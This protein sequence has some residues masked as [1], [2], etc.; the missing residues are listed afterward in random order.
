MLLTNNKGVSLILSFCL[1]ISFIALIAISTFSSVNAYNKASHYQNSTKAFWIA[2]AGVNEYLNNP[3]ILNKGAISID[4]D[5]NIVNVSKDDVSTDNR[6]LKAEGIVNGV[7]K[8]IELIFPRKTPEIF[9][10][11]VSSGGNFKI[12]GSP[13]VIEVMDTA[14][15]T[16]T[17]Q[18]LD[19]LSTARFQNLLEKSDSSLTTLKYPDL[20][21]NGKVNEFNDFII[22]NRELLASFPKKETI[23]IK[24]NSTQII[25]PNN[26]LKDKK[27]IY[28]EGEAPGA[29][30]VIIL[31]NASSA[32]NQDI[33]IISTGSIY[34]LQP[35]QLSEKSQINLIAWNNY[36]E[37]SIFQSK[38][39]GITFAHNK[40]NFSC[41]LSQSETNGSL[42]ANAGINAYEPLT[43][44]QFSYENLI[45]NEREIPAF[46]GLISQL[47]EGYSL[48]PI[49]IKEK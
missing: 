11:T 4:I 25:S 26:A 9:D 32:L 46:Q 29:G 40:A 31:F 24:S 18:K 6:I 22:F 41:I 8:R 12:H 21:G 15:I 3:D 27:I 30:S 33:T 44:K 19:F 34:Y 43:W 1:I 2:I 16:G 47:K 14:R 49:S 37:S 13:T 17:Q 39:K 42:I 45:I 10:S 20:N 7:Q 36:W 28:V 38:H 5:D 48:F 23:Y 35:L